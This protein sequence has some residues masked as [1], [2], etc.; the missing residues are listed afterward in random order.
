LKIFSRNFGNEF[1]LSA[2]YKF[3]YILEKLNSVNI[4]IN[5]E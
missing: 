3:W 1:S 5:L 2:A 4:N